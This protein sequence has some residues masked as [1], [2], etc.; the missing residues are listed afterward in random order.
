MLLLQGQELFVCAVDK[1]PAM[2]EEGGSGKSYA[3]RGRTDEERRGT[4]GRKEGM[5]SLGS[6]GMQ[7]EHCDSAECS[8]LVRD[9]EG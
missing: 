1:I 2:G 8:R 5:G 4:R 9:Q 6:E 7:R 3:V